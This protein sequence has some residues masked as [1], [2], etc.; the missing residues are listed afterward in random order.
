MKM[1]LLMKTRFIRFSFLSVLFIALSSCNL[2]APRQISSSSSKEKSSESISSSVTSSDYRDMTY[3]VITDEIE[4]AAKNYD[5]DFDPLSVFV[6]QK[7]TYL[8]AEPSSDYV[9]DGYFDPNLNSVPNDNSR[10]GVNLVYCFE[11]RFS[12]GYQGTYYTISGYLY[13]WDDGLF[14]GIIDDT[15]IVGYWYNSSIVDGVDENG[16][17]IMDC[18]KMVSCIPHYE[19]IGT[20]PTETG[21]YS[22]LAYVYYNTSWGGERSMTLS[23]YPYYPDVAIS[24]DPGDYIYIESVNYDAPFN[25]TIW[26]PVRVLKNLSCLPI[27]N[28]MEVEWAVGSGKATKENV[29]RDGCVV[30][31]V[32]SNHEGAVT[33]QYRNYR[34]SAEI[35]DIMV[36]FTGTGLQCVTARWKGFTASMF[37]IVNE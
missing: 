36:T 19:S 18:L 6:K 33:V 28:P 32:Y 5:Y 22:Y 23:G 35:S 1:R 26:T 13:L 24:L 7:E 21:P 8:F 4:E 20:S 10:T 9:G 27:L 14:G 15:D 34:S 2:L 31:T 25:A 17:D 29:T 30:S 3:K 12:E 11:G 37:V 16:K